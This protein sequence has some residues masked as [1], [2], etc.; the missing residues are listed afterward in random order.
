MKKLTI[1]FLPLLLAVAGGCSK[2][3]KDDVYP[4]IE[5]DC[6][7]GFPVNC[8]EIQ[9][10]T[11]FTFIAKFSDNAALGAFSL[12]IHHNFD[13]HTHSTDPLNCE[14]WP[15]KSPV[16]PFRL[17]REYEIPE[18]SESYTASVDIF[19]PAD[20]D[21]GDYHMMVRLTD[22]AG[23]QTIKGISFKVIE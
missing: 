14:F 8:D 5:M 15:I 20:A 22:K 23:W 12:D 18:G 21:T 4:E 17:I 10:G 9:R 6:C 3:E 16:N 13:H 7:G 2:E 19:I 1:L 11:T